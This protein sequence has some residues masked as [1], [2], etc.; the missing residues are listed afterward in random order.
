[1]CQSGTVPALGAV[2]L[3][4]AAEALEPEIA[5]GIPD[6]AWDRAIDICVATFLAWRIEPAPVA[7]PTPPGG[8]VAGPGSDLVAEMLAE[9]DAIEARRH[10]LTE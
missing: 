8:P 9:A 1:M 2:A 4:A 7:Y 3:T 5:A 10:A 6:M